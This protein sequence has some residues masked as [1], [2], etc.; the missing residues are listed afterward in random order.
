MLRNLYKSKWQHNLKIPPYSKNGSD[1]LSA[2]ESMKK[3][4]KN[5]NELIQD[6]LKMTDQEIM[7]KNVGKTDPKRAL[8]NDVE[9]IMAKNILQSIQTQMGVSGY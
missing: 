2:I 4:T 7:V 6:E 8:E 9:T 5:Y 3:Y 1:N